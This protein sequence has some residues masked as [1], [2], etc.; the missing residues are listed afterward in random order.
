MLP[1][2]STI[3]LL[4]YLQSEV[5]QAISTLHTTLQAPDTLETL[6]LYCGNDLGPTLSLLD[7]LD[8]TLT[9]MSASMLNI[10]NT[11]SCE[12]MVPYYINTVYEGVCRYSPH[13]IVWIFACS[14][15]VGLMGAIMTT[16]RVAYK[17]ILVDTIDKLPKEIDAETN[18]TAI[19]KDP[20]DRVE[21]YPGDEMDGLVSSTNDDDLNDATFSSF[22]DDTQSAAKSRGSKSRGSNS[23]PS[24]PG[25]MKTKK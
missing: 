14:L 15:I 1:F 22:Y 16:I 7:Q 19:L 8:Q 23:Q 20:I 3:P 24:R 21:S 18:S 13:A 10:F 4:L 12:R 9:S 25:K 6:S 2:D 17:E 5:Q 11:T